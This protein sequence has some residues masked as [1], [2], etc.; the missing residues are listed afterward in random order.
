MTSSGYGAAGTKA[1]KA[2]FVPDS[3]DYASKSINVTVTVNRK[4]ITVTADPKNKIYGSADPEFTFSAPEVVSRYPLSG[5]LAR[6]AGEDVGRVHCL[7]GI[8]CLSP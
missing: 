1:L 7:P 6:I 4:P 8:R 3:T 5:K 2:V